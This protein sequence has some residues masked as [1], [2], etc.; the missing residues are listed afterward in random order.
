[1]KHI[2]KSSMLRLSIV[3]IVHPKILNVMFMKLL[4]RLETFSANDA[5]KKPHQKNSTAHV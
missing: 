3:Q 2:W 1:M 4:Y 5:I